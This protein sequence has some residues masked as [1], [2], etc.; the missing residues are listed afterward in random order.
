MAGNKET[1]IGV[2]L[3]ADLRNYQKG[4]ST[5]QKETRQFKN[6]IKQNMGS[7]TASL[8]E[9]GRGNFAAL[10]D[11][12]RSVTKTVIG[13]SKGMKLLKTALIGSG[14]GAIVV[15]LASLA[16]AFTTSE[17]GA[18]KF[19]RIID[20][21]KVMFDNIIDVLA[22]LGEK[23]I[24]AF[25]HPKEAV[26]NLWEAIKQNFVN[27][28]NALPKLVMAAFKAI[29]S[30]FTDA[31][32]KDA[33]KEM[34]AAFTELTT[35]FDENDRKKISDWFKQNNV[36]MEQARQ[37]SD[38]I[39]ET[40]KKERQ[41]KIEKAKLEE[42]IAALRLKARENQD[43]DAAAALKYLNEA[44]TLQDQLL[45]VDY[46]IAKARFEI[47]KEQNTYARSSA[48][49]LNK[50]A[51][52]E[53]N[54]YQ[55]QAARQNSARQIQREINTLVNKLRPSLE[56]EARLR[57]AIA[58]NSGNY[59]TLET[60]QISTTFNTGE[61]DTSQLENMGNY[62][63]ANTQKARE[64]QQALLD[65]TAEENAERVGLL[66]SSFATMGA[67]IGGTAGSFLQMAAQ[68][69]NLVPQLIT[70]ITALTAAKGSEAISSGVAAAQNVPF[71]LNLIATAAT[72][73]SIISALATKP[74]KL[75][76]GGIAYGD[77]LARVGE[78]AGAGSNP[79][80]IAPLDKLKNMLPNA[81]AQ[82]ETIIPSLHLRD[83]HIE[84]MFNRAQ[85]RKNKRT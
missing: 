36:E 72:V 42:K 58:K 30:V 51:E 29:K 57:E 24:W 67:A 50:E 80:V 61:V 77:T 16:A 15:V 1:S 32:S 65:A 37:L 12:F 85:R 17:E 71:P 33:L 76:A 34:G 13:A 4:L 23:I 82:K 68:V 78:Y 64:L 49:N 52:L 56:A 28:V 27:R 45:K 19:R 40:D 66:S 62:L 25:E 10:P 69:L 3:T 11:L 54:L 74:P 70:Q 5:A 7:V 2:K 20:P 55:I 46:E 83:D 63:D 31:S 18:A 41:Q 59:S 8:R 81:Q 22:D 60:K 43:K 44:R 84:I 53:A 14:I 79:E 26:N 47:Q 6:A 35:G 21:F 39:L 38:K 48:E 75:A 9:V 73:A